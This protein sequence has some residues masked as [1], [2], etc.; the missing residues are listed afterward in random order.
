MN[1]LTTLTAKLNLF[2]KHLLLWVARYFYLRR[3]PRLVPLYATLACAPFLIF[4]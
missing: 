2:D 4:F 3:H 1:E